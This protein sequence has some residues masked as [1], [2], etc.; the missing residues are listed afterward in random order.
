MNAYTRCLASIA[1]AAAAGL[2]AAADVGRVVLAAG[3]TT[4]L[5][6]GQAVRLSLGTMVQDA[7]TLRTGAGSNLQ[8]RFEDDSYVSMR[9][10]SELRVQEFRFSGQA[11]GTERALF[12]LVKGGM[13]AITGLIGRV[14]HDNYRMT[15]PTST[16]GIRGTDYAATLCQGDCR[17]A[18]GSPAKDGL[19]GH[20]IGQSGGTN[21]IVV[22][23]DADSRILGINSNFFVGDRK[24]TI[25]LL[26][27]APE[28]V[29][30]KL[31]GRSRGGSKGSA[32]GTGNEQATSGGASEESRPSTIPAPLPQLQFVV[33]QQLGPL[34]GP[35]VLASSSLA[36]NGFAVAY[37]LPN[38]NPNFGEFFFDNDFLKGT[39]NALGQLTDYGTPGVIPAGSL[40]GGSITDTGSITLANG[41]T[42][43]F[44]RW[45][46]STSNL[47]ED[48]TTFVGAPVL[49][50]T[51]TGLQSNSSVV[52]TLG[53]VATYNYAGGPKP[54]DA[55]G[56][57]GSITS[58]SN[59]INFT[60]L[61]QQLSLGMNFPS[62]LVSGTNT[63]PAVFNLSTS[64]SASKAQL[65]GPNS[66]G[67][68][69]GLGEFFGVLSGSCSG[70]GCLSASAT[71]AYGTGLTG[72]NGYE[73]S[74]SAGVVSGTKAGD[75]AFLNAYTL[76][77]F[78]PGPAPAPLM[79]G[80]IAYANASPS[81]P[82]A[83]F[84]LSTNLTVFS[85]NNPVAFSSPNSSLSA[86]LAGG[87]IIETGSVGLADGGTMNWGRW[88]GATQVF[89]PVVGP[90]SP[91]TGVPFVVG[92]ANTVHPTSGT[93]VYSYAGGPNPVNINGTTGTFG[94]G[95]FNISF[96]ATSGSLSVATPLTMSVGGVSYSLGTC[97]GG[98]SFS[99]ASVGN[100]SLTG[101]CSGGACS[102]GGFPANANA[103][104]IFVG[105]QGAG[106]AVAGNVTS[107]APTVTFAAGFKR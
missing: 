52:G 26:L 64:F 1:L 30:S 90:I 15:T 96:G 9:E 42:L 33:T 61:T 65:I 22:S 86:S 72:P 24:S 18:D 87:T 107:I 101:T 46:G 69:P 51:V 99:G 34:G 44:G 45:T 21:Q 40:N 29:L 43:T 47:L 100:M 88:S 66:S 103:A 59:T 3:E 75:V 23:N 81:V 31:E 77:S 6:Q 13:R 10:N 104:G 94:G 60:A 19:Y 28:F 4:A 14:N 76:N 50:G 7:D 16:I 12:D 55:G 73:G 8:V 11:D 105:P 53:G 25:E 82:G 57:V 67:N 5:R 56:N 93:F 74:V 41:Q 106:L 39:Y 2:A 58:A 95:A 32:G 63:G 35:V 49:F 79:T 78:T 80:Q 97:V 84:S 98:C 91:S 85:G 83:T 20:V 62:I 38:T 70:S 92:P 36:P 37:P 54:V 89:D 68:V 17:N 48:G 102:V 27:V 71:G